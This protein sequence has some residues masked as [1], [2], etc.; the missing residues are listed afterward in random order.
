MDQR[1][2]HTAL[3]AA[4]I[5]SADLD[6]AR[7]FLARVLPWPINGEAYVGIHWN[8]KNDPLVTLR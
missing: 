3:P 6:Q 4:S 8:F 7:R 2:P 1:E 5:A